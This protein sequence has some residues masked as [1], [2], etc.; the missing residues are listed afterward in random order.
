MKKDNPK[1]VLQVIKSMSHGGAETMIMNIYRNIEKNK[2]QFYFLC[3]SEKKGDYE[4]EIEKLGGKIY[5][6]K[7]PDTGR[8]RNL[9]QIYKTI[10]KIKKQKEII[11]IHSHVSYY[12]GFVNFAA[13]LAG[14]KTRIAHSHTTSDIRKISFIR[15]IYNNFSKIMI[16][17]FSNVKLSCG[18]KAGEY[19]YTKKDYIIFNNGIDLEKYTEVTKEQCYELR[20]ELDIKEKDF[21][22][23]HVGRFEKVKNQIYFIELAKE[24]K[25]NRNDFKIVLVG[26]GTLFESIKNK[27]IDEGLEKFFVLPGLRN[28][29]NVFMNMFDIFILPSLY[30]GFPLVVVEALA[31][32]NNCYISKNVSSET[33]VID[34]MVNFFDLNENISILINKINKSKKIENINIEQI[35]KEKGYSI[36][37]MTKKIEQIYTRENN[38]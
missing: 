7:S 3:M 15:K 18:E 33:K 31:G 9:L 32:K 1:I 38:K 28:D 29:I 19:L 34:N 27:I 5:R 16:N 23:G 25:K 30:E 24:M 37:D 26:N 22:I 17:R 6:V 21:V 2:I 14:I 8:I 36:V 35:L 13:Y 11:A 4:N 12:S 20:K 10:K